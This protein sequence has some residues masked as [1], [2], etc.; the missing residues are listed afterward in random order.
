[1]STYTPFETEML[2]MMKELKSDVSELKSDVSELK[3]DV[4]ELKSDMIS[5]KWQLTRIETWNDK[6]FGAI[7]DLRT[8]LRSDG[9]ATRGMIYEAYDQ[10]AELKDT[11][12]TKATPT[13]V[14]TRYPR[15]AITR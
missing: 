15:V 11:L 8:E 6:A 3:S 2:I 1:M 4:S 13:V 12:V 9:A 7:E 5:V 14:R 10:V